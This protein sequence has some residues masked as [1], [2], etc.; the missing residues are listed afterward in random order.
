MKTIEFTAKIR[1]MAPDD[2]D[3][4]RVVAFRPPKRGEKFLTNGGDIQV[5]TTDWDTC[6]LIIDDWQWPE[7]LTA[8]AMV[9]LPDGRWVETSRVPT[10]QDDDWWDHGEYVEAQ[11]SFVPP[12]CDDWRK[13]LRI[14]PKINPSVPKGSSD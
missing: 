13:S 4:G 14:N 6:R 7:G 1:W 8:A 3:P 5:A 9:M 2:F 10:I 11:H 12:P